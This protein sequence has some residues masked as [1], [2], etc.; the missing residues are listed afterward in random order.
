MNNVTHAQ[1]RGH[2]VGRL[3]PWRTVAI[4]GLAA[5]AA[6][7]GQDA[8]PA[9]EAASTAPAATEAPAVADRLTVYTV[10]YPLAYFATRIGGDRVE[11]V[12]PAPP[13][14]DPAAWAPEGQDIAAFQKANVILLN[15]AGYAGWTKLVS[16]PEDRLVNTSESFADRYL[17]AEDEA[18]H[19]HGPDGDHS[20]EAQI[21]FTT[22]L[23]PQLAIAQAA[24]IRDALSA[25]Q[26][27]AAAEFTAGFESLQADLQAL[28]QDLT[29]LF[30]QLGDTPVVFS[31]PVYQYLQKRYG[32]NGISVHW[33]PDETPSEEQMMELADQLIRHPARM[34]IWE[35]DPKAES[36]E[37][38][39]AMTVD[40]VP[41]DPCGNRPESGDYMTVMR[42]NVANLRKAISG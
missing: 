20:H 41:L 29:A 21:A 2:L 24:A 12:F 27:D 30:E 4:G 1:V 28:D 19:S 17:M 10:N 15:G 33:E 39:D 38:L 14:G 32:I 5:L 35:G 8:P 31:H 26:P 7:C 40:S 34:M 42:E 18:T 16:L 37:A 6:A 36:V 9:T 13:D 25:R 3:R 23:D 11:V 22:W